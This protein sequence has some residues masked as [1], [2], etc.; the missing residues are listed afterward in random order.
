LR[1]YRSVRDDEEDA[2]KRSLSGH[3]LY[4]DAQ[5]IPWVLNHIDCIV[6]QSRGNKIVEGVALHPYD[7]LDGHDDEAWDKLGQSIGNL[8]SLKRLTISNDKSY[9]Q[10]FSISNWERLALILR[11]MRQMVGVILEIDGGDLWTVEE[12]QALARAIRG[13][14]TITSWL[15]HVLLRSLGCVV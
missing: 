10:V 11:H 2:C 5:T 4:L 12:A 1:R 7:F 6:S 8:Q 9:G 13:H 15:Q 3:W 14:P